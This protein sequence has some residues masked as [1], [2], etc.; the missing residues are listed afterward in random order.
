MTQADISE[1]EMVNYPAHYLS[2]PSK[3]EVID[4]TRHLPFGIGNAVK[5]VMRAPHKQ[6][7]QRDLAKALWYLSDSI[8]HNLSYTIN[9]SLD[10]L[11]Q[12]VADAEP[13]PEVAEIIRS[14]C[15]RNP[16]TNKP[17]EKTAPAFW[18]ARRNLA[19]LQRQVAEESAA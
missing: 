12:R 5:Y 19:R 2:H 18:R 13:N 16:Y 4:L 10:A 9:P 15:C 11:A 7:P 8:G 1:Y 6:N 14:L 17:M 3:V